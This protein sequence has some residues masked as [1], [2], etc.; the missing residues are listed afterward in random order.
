VRC[1]FI[2][3]ATALRD[4][5]GAT[6]LLVH[7]EGKNQRG[8]RGSS[9]L[10]GAA[11]VVIQVFREGEHVVVRGEKSKDDTP[12]TAHYFTTKYVDLGTDDEGDA[13]G[14]L[15]LERGVRRRRRTPLRRSSLETTPAEKPDRGATIRH[16]LATMM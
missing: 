13:V 16:R 8:L 9:A 7:H 3:L 10:H 12:L 4:A 5:T 2:A 6:I 1:R 15:V 14:S 11:D